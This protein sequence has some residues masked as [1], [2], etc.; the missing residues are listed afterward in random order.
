MAFDIAKFKTLSPEAQQIVFQKQNISPKAQEIIMQKIGM[1]EQ[2]ITTRATT[3]EADVAGL[4]RAE[5]TIPEIEV[6]SF[7]ELPG[8]IP[9][10]IFNVAKGI[11]TAIVNPIETVDTMRDIVLGGIAKA[12][13]PIGSI[14][15]QKFDAMV[16]FFADRYGG[17]ENMR[18]TAI[19]DPAGFA[20]D[21]SA[22]LTGT[23]G[24]IRTAGTTGKVQAITKAGEAITKVGRAVDPLK[25]TGEVVGAVA[26]LRK[27]KNTLI[28][29]ALQFRQIVKGE[30]NR[31]QRIDD[32][33]QQFLESDFKVNRQSMKRVD[34]NRV[35][36]NKDINR[37]IDQSTEAGVMKDIQPIVDLLDDTINTAIDK[38][39]EANSINLMI[40]LKNDFVAVRGQ[41]MSPRELQTLKKG[42]NEAFKPNLSSE[43]GAIKDV[44][45][46]KQRQGARIILED[47][48][49]ELKI[50]NPEDATLKQF[51]Q[52]ISRRLE[53]IEA[54]PV[55]ASKGL[56]AGG[57]AGAG[58]G[59][60]TQEA[61]QAV[62][63]GVTAAL[64]SKLVD[65]PNV[66]IAIARMLHK[67]NMQLA[68]AG[69]LSIGPRTAFQA[70]RIQEQAQPQITQ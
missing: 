44:M 15:E 48:H 43:F 52:A 8:N 70:G 69:K 49:P 55:V 32:L 54:Q 45:R 10:S 39:L 25:V 38:G 7:K 63:F 20:L 13:D 27:P 46:S 59:A 11:T 35:R 21:L 51:N 5:A 1:Q 28:K 58:A 37:L 56:V 50:L 31:L 24:L 67:A 2:P 64:F 14:E 41:R 12:V 23:G 16:D 4:A 47:L 30:K 40:K 29:T 22:V 66:Q 3:G 53:T 36:V 34:A 57:V 33:A 26:R 18:E 6:P 68:N 19:E 17:I 42:L 9:K 65:S 60:I 61:G 62:K